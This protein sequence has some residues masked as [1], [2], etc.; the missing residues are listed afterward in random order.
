MEAVLAALRILECYESDRGLRAADIQERCGLQY[1]RVMRLVGT[2][3]ARGFLFLDIDSGRYHLGPSL[4]RLGRLLQDRYADLASAVRPVLRALVEE[5]DLTAMFS[6]PVGLSRLVL[7]KEEPS[8]ALRYTVSEGQTRSMHQG[9]SGRV[10]LAFIDDEARQQ[11]LETLGS[12][13]AA[14]LSE[15]IAEVA[16]QRFDISVSELTKGAFAIARPILGS[17]G[18]LIGVLSLAGPSAS[19]TGALQEKY[20]HLLE[21]G[22]ARVPGASPTFA[23]Q[24]QS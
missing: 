2:L 20:L 9:A 1:S 24:S 19:L 5:T 8:S 10:M 15:V 7:C 4:L 13:E 18:E 6:V 14:Q 17:D 21:Q 23:H 3:T 11:V 16:V 22:A 12:V